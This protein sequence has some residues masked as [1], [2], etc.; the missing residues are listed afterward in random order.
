MADVPQNLVL[1]GVEHHVEC[2]GEF[3]CAEI[4]RQVPAVLGNHVD[5]PFANLLGQ[6]GEFLSR[7]L[8]EVFRGMNALKDL[9]HVFE[10]GFQV[11]VKKYN[12][13]IYTGNGL[14]SS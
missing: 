7:E 3:D 4:R 1:R 13:L 9:F 14:F 10:A 12:L 8:P 11:C 6:G 2:N 5:D